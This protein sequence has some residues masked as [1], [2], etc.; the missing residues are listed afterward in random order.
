MGVEEGVIGGVEAG[1]KWVGAREK[2]E[3]GRREV[4]RGE[5]RGKRGERRPMY[6][7]I[8]TQRIFF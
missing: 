2:G 3:R 1:G 4:D 5:E 8:S 6:W 7:K